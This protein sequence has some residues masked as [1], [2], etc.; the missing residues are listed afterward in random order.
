[1]FS[2][3]RGE[4]C[5]NAYMLVYERKIKKPMKIVITDKTSVQDNPNVISYKQEER[6]A[7]MKKYDLTRY[8]GTNEYEEKCNELY[9]SVFY[10]VEKDEYYKY[11]PFYYNN[12]MIPKE[13]YIEIERDNSEFEKMKN[14]SDEH[15]TVFFNK[16]ISLLEEAILNSKDA[17]EERKNGE[18]RYMTSEKKR[19]YLASADENIQMLINQQKEELTRVL[20]ELKSQY[21]KLTKETSIKKREI[22]ELDKKIAML[23]LMDS[24]TKKKFDE[25]NSNN[26]NMKNAIEIKKKKKEEE[27][28]TKKTLSKQIEKL[29]NDLLLVQKEIIMLENDTKKLNK[30]YEKERSKQNEIKERYNA[31]YSKIKDQNQRNKFEKNEQDLQLQYYQTIIDQK[32]QF[33]QSADE[34]KE[35]QIKIAQ[36]A[37]NDSQDKQ[38]VEKRRELELVMLY[39]TYLRHKMDEQLKTNEKLERTFQD[40]RDICVS[41]FILTPQGTS[42]LRIIVDKILNKDKIYNLCVQTVSEK[43]KERLQLKGELAELEKQ[44]IEL[45]NDSMFIIYNII[46]PCKGGS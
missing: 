26:E 17:N 6:A 12:R 41:I 42:N 7:I 40:I 32:Y 15:F 36:E 2:W 25:V 5:K 27:L 21:D 35:R 39:N 24:K 10:D 1:M 18:S 16:M 22:D 44:Y 46:S 14:I 13:Y 43:E 19:Y 20:I 45:K 38:E 34:R 3:G 28:Y 29:K 23:E 30:K 33:I 37:K 8:Y 31:V 11:V 9:Q 4:K